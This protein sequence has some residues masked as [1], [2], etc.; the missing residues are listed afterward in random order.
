MTA[1]WGCMEGLC[2]GCEGGCTGQWRPNDE[3]MWWCIDGPK[4]SRKD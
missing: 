3:E 4:R 1:A 2:L